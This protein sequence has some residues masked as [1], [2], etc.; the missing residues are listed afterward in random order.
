MKLN[1]KN[2]IIID[3]D[4]IVTTPSN[5]GDSLKDVIDE[6]HKD[7][8]KLKSN[9]KFIYSYGGIGGSGKGG[10]G[11][12]SVKE[13]KLYAE[14]KNIETGESKQINLDIN[15][16]N[17][18]ILPKPGAYRFYAKLSNSGGEKFFLKYATGSNSIDLAQN[19]T[20]STDINNCETP[21]NSNIL[22]TNGSIKVRLQN[23]DGDILYNIEQRYIVEPHDFDISFMY[24]SNGNT[25]R[26]D[27]GN[28]HF[29]GDTTRDPFININYS[30]NLPQASDIVVTYSI[31][32]FV[33]EE[34]ECS[35]T[36][37][38]IRI[39]L[40]DILKDGEPFL[41]DE[42]VGSYKVSVNFGYRSAV[43]TESQHAK[44]EFNISLIPSSLFINIT[45]SLN[46]LY[47]SED[48]IISE[49]G[50]QTIPKRTLN[51]G[52]YLTLYQL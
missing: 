10:S 48:E 41:R 46:I 12:G 15:N 29:L 11:G 20:L 51:I 38:T 26:Y 13:P 22:T 37:D 42:N 24:L 23:S 34:I 17:P 6:H 40:K 19:I 4:I 18:L 47:D 39:F 9:M 21:E 35:K 44:D 52:A 43:V 1:N 14:L 7:I 3:D 5:I 28:E 33:S 2:R 31:G 45:P 25:N 36:S 27:S 49:M 50:E 8:E 32:D 30:I 16:T